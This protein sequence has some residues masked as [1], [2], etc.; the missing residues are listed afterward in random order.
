MSGEPTNM[1]PISEHQTEQ[2]NH[3]LLEKTADKGFEANFL[4]EKDQIHGPQI[5]ICNRYFYSS[6][7]EA[8]TQEF[9]PEAPRK[10]IS[11]RK[12]K[13]NDKKVGTDKVYVDRSTGP[14]SVDLNEKGF[15][16]CSTGFH[17][18]SSIKSDQEMLALA[19][20]TMST[21]NVFN[22]LNWDYTTQHQGYSFHLQ[23]LWWSNQ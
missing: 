6:H 21:Y 2:G 16:K 15:L 10:H 9:F 22:L 3:F 18:V 13:K 17:E 14:D 19:G 1:Q 20:V 4:E 5:F 8:E 11:T 7:G 23:V 12:V